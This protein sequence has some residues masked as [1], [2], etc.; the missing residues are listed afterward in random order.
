MTSHIK[1]SQKLDMM[2]I[3]AAHQKDPNGIAWK[4]NRDFENLLKRLNAASGTAETTVDVEMKEEF[5][6]ETT[7]QAKE[8]ARDEEDE[9]KEEKE[10]TKRKREVV[11]EDRSGKKKRR[12]SSEE[13]SPEK[14]SKEVPTPAPTP[15]PPKKAAPPRH[16][17]Y[18][19]YVP[20]THTLTVS[21]LS[22]IVTVLERLPPNPSLTNH[23]STSP[24]F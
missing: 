7:V 20:I 23:P 10:E 13:P 24:K 22:H 11:V 2:G 12:N 18:V 4:Q 8:E 21:Y 1:V 14:E 5:V 17:A 16:R 19:H 6:A 15:V 9:K 3:G